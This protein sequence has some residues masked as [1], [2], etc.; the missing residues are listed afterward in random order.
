[1]R[2]SFLPGE[3]HLN[4]EDSGSYVITVQSEEVLR[5]SQ[6]RK[7]LAKFNALRREMEAQFPPHELSLEEKRAILQKW[8]T[9][10]KVALGYN[11]L[12]TPK[13]KISTTRTFG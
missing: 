8:I 12:R 11:S 9:D 1:M 4:K 5:T 6:E 7:A 2:L 10:S 3:L 13:K